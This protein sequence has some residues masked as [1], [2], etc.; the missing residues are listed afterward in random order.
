M[1]YATELSR[2]EILRILES[3]YDEIFVTNAEGVV[4]Y[5]NSS[6]ASHYGQQAREMV[7]KR[8]KEMTEQNLWGPRLSPLA[9]R[10]KKRLT[11]KQ[12]SCTGV[13]MLT[14]AS[15]VFNQQG[16][17]DYI[18]ENVRNVTPG[19]GI[20]QEIEDSQ[21]FF[22]EIEESIESADKEELTIENFV[23]QS[24]EM[25]A[26]I[27][28][29]WRISAVNSNV[30]ITGD[31]GAGKSIIARYIHDK[32]PRNREPFIEINCAAL[33]EALIESELF[34]YKRGAFSGAA[35]QGKK[36][37]IETAAQGTL[38]LD[39]IG[40]L[41]ITVQ[42]KLLRFIQ[43]GSYFEVGG[44]VEKHAACR[45]IAATNRD[46]PEMV[47]GKKFRQDLYYRLKVFEINIPPLSQRRDDIEPLVNF[48]LHKFNEK[49]NVNRSLAPSCL[50]ALTDYTWPGNVRELANV[51]EQIV[52]MAA[53]DAITEQSL[54]APLRQSAAASGPSQGNQGLQEQHAGLSYKERFAQITAEQAAAEA[55]LFTAMYRELK[56]SRRIARTLGLSD[57]AAYRY[58]KKYCPEL[59]KK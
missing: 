58:L 29:A 9:Q 25:Q 27:K 49:Y 15:P 33:P 12:L 26:I 54:P 46:L 52:V 20:G 8:S 11:R 3:S 6:C 57:S 35:S 5:V 31:S 38:F 16:E 14:T 21:S 40:E 10:Y 36:G 39:E 19:A 51:M 59:L 43:D 7:G 13:T 48:Y 45:V 18:I 42:A 24:R 44:T 23:A 47:A 55:Q 22:K 1:K 41:P 34:G 50:T 56:S 53:E 28:M 37:L 30:L 4:V 17:V 2:E 32:S